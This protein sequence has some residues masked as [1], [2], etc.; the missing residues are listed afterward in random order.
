MYNIKAN[1]NSDAAAN[2]IASLK[3]S[4]QNVLTKYGYNG[5]KNAY[6]DFIITECNIPRKSIDG[7]IGSDEAQRNFLIKAAVIAQKSNI[8]GLYIYSAADTQPCLL[9][10]SRCV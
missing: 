5:T 7:Y 10:T 2:S 6:K 3:E 9:Y 8:N 1:P 4:F